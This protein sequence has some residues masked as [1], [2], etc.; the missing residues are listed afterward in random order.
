VYAIH[1]DREG[2]VWFVVY[3]SGLARYDG[4]SIELYTTAD[5]LPDLNVS[6]VIEDAQ[7]R[8][9]A[10]STGGLVVSEKPLGDYAPGERVHFTGT[11][12]DTRCRA[13]RSTP[14]VLRWIR[15]GGCGRAR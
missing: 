5:G 13:P 12:G 10:G 2:L 1:Q 9:W 8:L 4:H 3:S 6:D 7:G 14:T 11:F 15:R